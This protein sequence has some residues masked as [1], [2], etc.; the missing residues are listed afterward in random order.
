MAEHK[1]GEMNIDDHEKTFVSFVRV[2]KNVMILIILALI[3]LAMF[4]A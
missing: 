1:H 3:L 4:N 2:T